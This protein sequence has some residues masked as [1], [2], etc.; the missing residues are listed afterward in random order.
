MLYDLCNRYGGGYADKEI[1]TA[2]L[3]G[4]VLTRVGET[5]NAARSIVGA[6]FIILVYENTKSRVIKK[7]IETE[8]RVAKVGKHVPEN[9]PNIAVDRVTDILDKISGLGKDVVSVSDLK[10]LISIGSQPKDVLLAIKD[11]SIDGGKR[12]DVKKLIVLLN[13]GDT[14]V[15]SNI[16]VYEEYDEYNDFY[17]GLN[18]PKPSVISDDNEFWSILRTLH[19]SDHPG[20]LR[21]AAWALL[22]AS[23][24]GDTWIVNEIQSDMLDPAE[25]ELAKAAK[26]RKG[27]DNYFRKIKEYGLDRW[28]YLVMNT[29]VKA[30]ISSG[31][32]K[33]YMATPDIISKRWDGHTSG[34]RLTHL[35]Q[36]VPKKYG[37]KLTSVG[38][39]NTLRKVTDE[40]L[41]KKVPSK[42]SSRKIKMWY[43]DLSKIRRTVR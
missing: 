33:L 5:S 1:A 42:P 28:P 37:F 2:L 32:S 23:P 4:K 15:G 20:N 41:R 39:N 31:V 17:I 43:L 34:R 21:T 24:R 30:A 16:G 12:V 11:A 27:I 3:S 26:G 29:V 19:N 14:S 13:E 10:K 35:Y 8:Y 9:P 6:K 40:P 25:V 18:I 22:F 38:L 36:T 7:E